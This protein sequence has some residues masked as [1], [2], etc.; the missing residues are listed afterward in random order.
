MSAYGNVIIQFDKA[1]SKML[2]IPKGVRDLLL[3]PER[4]ITVN[5]PVRMDN[6]AMKVFTGFRI[7]H[8]SNRG[9][10]KGGIRY[11]PH[12]NK[13]KVTALSAWMTFKC[14]VMDLPFGGAKGGVICDPHALSENELRRLTEAYTKAITPII[15][16]DKDIPAPD[17]G[18]DSRIMKWMCRAYSK[19]VGK[20]NY[21]VVTG[22]PLDYGG[23][24]GRTQATGR[25]VAI[26]TN[27][28]CGDVKGKTVA[29]QGFGN[30][31]KHAAKTLY[32]MDAKIIAIS[33]I[34]GEIY[35][36]DG[37]D[38]DSIITYTESRDGTLKGHSQLRGTLNILETECDILIPA[39]LEDQITIDNA[40]KVK[41]KYIVEGAN[42]PIT[43]IAE[44]VLLRKK[45]VIAPD[46]LANAGGVT[47]S[48]YEW[49]Q[50]KFDEHWTEEKVNGKLKTKMIS[51]YCD[52]IVIA[53][54]YG[55]DM[56][57]S[58]YILAIK[59]VV[60]SK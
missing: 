11:C 47:V 46:I 26:I 50:N 35:D 43:P 36:K 38:I 34:N 10:Y 24:L 12:M 25:G 31:G 3:K 58:A 19:E 60:G 13:D 56:R 28:I 22:K 40:D 53:K 39:A 49:I 4:E 9:P 18:T 48:Y 54:K 59:R 41:A 6:G 20:R 17:I 30:V 1:V 42:G 7:Q 8:N 33:D 57:T 37:I 15:G 5:F 14:A 44:T 45:T 32:D 52:V 23:S 2:Y 51:A 16:P 21:G 29:I 55:T 27:E